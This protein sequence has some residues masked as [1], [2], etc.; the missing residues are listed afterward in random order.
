ML[1]PNHRP[2]ATLRASTPNLRPHAE[3]GNAKSQL[4]LCWARIAVS[5]A[6]S[7]SVD[8]LCH[9]DSQSR[10]TAG[11][12]Q[13]SC[14]TAASSA[15]HGSEYIADQLAQASM[16]SASGVG[17]HDVRITCR[18]SDVLAAEARKAESASEVARRIPRPPSLIGR[19]AC[20]HCMSERSE[21]V[22]LLIPSRNMWSKTVR[23]WCPAYGTQRRVCVSRG[24][25]ND[26]RSRMR[27]S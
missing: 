23:N 18:R 21:F 11:V 2:T 26:E 6:L 8:A 22:M 24:T 9:T 12:S 10:A 19:L 7:V 16:Y 27:A 20:S 25:L 3:M 13:A 5:L 1:S 15:G 14:L 17:Q 4:L